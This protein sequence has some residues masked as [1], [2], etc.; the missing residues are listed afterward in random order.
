MTSGEPTAGC[1]REGGGRR[2]GG[3]SRGEAAP[4]R[5]EEESV[6]GRWWGGWEPRLPCGVQKRGQPAGKAVQGD[7][8]TS[9][10]RG[11][12]DA[13]LYQKEQSRGA[14]ARGHRRKTGDGAVGEEVV[15]TEAQGV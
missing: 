13:E 8:G 1:H 7:R 12:V 3:L 4:C 5:R 6:C 15:G 2:T 14:S 9:K 10:G 11:R